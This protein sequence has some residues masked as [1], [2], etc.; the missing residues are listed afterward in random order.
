MITDDP[1]TLRKDHVTHE[2]T[3][4]VLQNQNCNESLDKQ[5]Q[6]HATQAEMPH[7]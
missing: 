4:K 3:K 7:T 5:T 2:M 6:V 1:F